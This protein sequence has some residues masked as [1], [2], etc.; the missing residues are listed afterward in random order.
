LYKIKDSFGK[1]LTSN[2]EN[3]MV[4]INYKE[5]FTIDDFDN[6]NN[7]LNSEE[8]QNE[9]DNINDTSE[10]DNHNK[11]LVDENANNN[12]VKKILNKRIENNPKA[13]YHNEV[14]TSKIVTISSA[15]TYFTISKS[16]IVGAS[17]PNPNNSSNN[18]EN[19]YKSSRRSSVK[20]PKQMRKLIH[21]PL[22]IEEKQIPDGF[23]AI[24]KDPSID[25]ISTTPVKLK[26][27]DESKSIFYNYRANQAPKSAPISRPISRPLSNKARQISSA[28]SKNKESKSNDKTNLPDELQPITISIIKIDDQETGHSIKVRKYYDRQALRIKKLNI[29]SETNKLIENKKA[30][31]YCSNLKAAIERSVEPKKSNFKLISDNFKILN[32]QIEIKLPDRPQNKI[33]AQNSVDNDFKHLAKNDEVIGLK[34]SSN[35]EATLSQEIKF[36]NEE[37]EKLTN[38]MKDHLDELN[39]SISSAS[40]N[41]KKTIPKSPHS[42]FDINALNDDIDNNLLQ[43]EEKYLSKSIEIAEN[44]TSIDKIKDHLD[45]LNQSISSA[46]SNQKKTI[47]KSPYSSFNMNAL[48]DDIDNN[49]LQEEEKYLSKSIEITE[50]NIS[51]NNIVD[52]PADMNEESFYDFINKTMNNSND[53]INNNDND[54]KIESNNNENNLGEIKNVFDEK[55]EIEEEIIQNS[56]SSMKVNYNDLNHVDNKIFYDDSELI[57]KNDKK[58]YTSYADVDIDTN[59]VDTGTYKLISEIIT[60]NRPD[61]NNL[62]TEKTELNNNNSNYW[63]LNLTNE[64]DLI[65]ENHLNGDQSV[66]TENHFEI[67]IDIIENEK[68]EEI[69]P[70]N[71]TRE[72]DNINNVIENQK[73]LNQTV[74]IN[75]GHEN[76]AEEQLELSNVEHVALNESHDS[77]INMKNKEISIVLTEKIK[78]NNSEVDH[79]D[80]YLENEKNINHINNL[81]EKKSSENLKEKQNQENKLLNEENIMQTKQQENLNKVDKGLEKV[82]SLNNEEYIKKNI[83]LNKKL[84]HSDSTSNQVKN[85][86]AKSNLGIF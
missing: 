68:N 18:Y 5:T 71:S 56:T 7:S 19:S 12:S 77:S 81:N 23:F 1:K 60:Y 27:Q 39:Q 22:K 43:E 83:I 13:N 44:I 46:S 14:E 69:T 74:F 62:A 80:D 58:H 20:S 84:N 61:Y 76:H 59:N 45:E 55:Q 41:Q 2:I 10:I 57:L 36:N 29:T 33:K 11:F 8:N 50:N 35:T 82:K 42:S 4:T 66:K 78:Q 52:K 40:S 53:V 37:I 28:H 63:E 47:P 3:S 72:L 15:P 85:L 49:L 79:D 67:V 70:S 75:E 32:P 54:D 34:K 24:E 16:A 51:N 26:T 21:S 65:E 30:T 6:L 38:K 25:F 17:T 73:E 64:N 86:N 48:N 31:E 9:N